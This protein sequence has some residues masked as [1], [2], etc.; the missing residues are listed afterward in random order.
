[1]GTDPEK[2]GAKKRKKERKKATQRFVAAG[3]LSKCN[4]E[5]VKCDKEKVKE[6]NQH[7]T[8]EM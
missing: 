3:R 2:V 6:T 4:R 7:K 8:T 1:L 5:L